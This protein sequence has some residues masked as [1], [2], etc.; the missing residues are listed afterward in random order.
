MQSSP[1]GLGKSE[2]RRSILARRDAM[3]AEER[4]DASEQ[5]AS[6]TFPVAIDGGT[7]VSGFFPIRS[8]INPIPLMRRLADRGAPL[9]LPVLVAPGEPLVFRSWSFGQPLAAGIW[10]IREPLAD[11]PEVLPDVLIVP[12]LAFDRRGNRL[13]YGAGYYDRTLHR[14]RARKPVVAIGLA[15]AI[16]EIPDVPVTSR[17]ARLD[18]VLTDRETIDCRGT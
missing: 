7:R 2:V 14:L 15:F 3:P 4:A 5:V 1:H 12:L 10:G 17:D 18:L 11:A 6:K 16:Q 8:E 13:G 9:A